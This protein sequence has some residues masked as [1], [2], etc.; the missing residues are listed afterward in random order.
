MCIAYCFSKRK[1]WSA[2]GERKIFG[3]V[4]IQ[5]K[6]LFVYGLHEDCNILDIH[7]FRRKNLT[8]CDMC[9]RRGYTVAHLLGLRVRSPPGAS[10]SVSW[11]CCVL[12]GRGFCFRLI[13]CREESCRLWCVVVCDLETSWIKRPWPNGGCRGQNKQNDLS[14]K[15][16]THSFPI[17][18]CYELF[19]T[20]V[21]RQ[22]RPI[23]NIMWCVR[24]CRR[25]G[26]VTLCRAFHNVVRDYKHNKKTKGT[27]LVKLFTAT[28]KLKNVI[29]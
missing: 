12:L 1:S 9:L 2:T 17:T 25:Q 7:N 10:T 22:W 5:I 3:T 26:S 15:S 24:D 13:T 28:G 23:N 21:K 6:C 29:F 11:E 19:S 16:N 4:A 8:R 18:R 14:V 20:P 27:N